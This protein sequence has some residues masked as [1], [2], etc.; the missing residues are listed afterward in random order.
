MQENGYESY[1]TGYTNKLC[2]KD[3]MQQIDSGQSDNFQEAFLNAN[4]HSRTTALHNFR[5]VTGMTPSE[6]Y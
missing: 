5:Q 6:Y 3:F 4:F 2:I 1:Y